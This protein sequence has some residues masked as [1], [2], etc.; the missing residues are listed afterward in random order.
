M[1]AID[2]NV[3]VRFLVEDDAAQARRARSIVAQAV[4][5]STP[6]YLSD[7][8]VCETVW[9]LES[10]YGLDRPAIHDVLR[11]LVGARHLKFAS[12]DQITYATEAYASGKGDFADYLIREHSKKAEC[13]VVY[14][15][16]KALW[17]E[18]GFAKL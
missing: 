5:D 1:I 9:V 2:T 6:V 14:T 7:I 13:T 8:V 15:F 18:P 17:S 4:H 11:S 16:D 10:C 3:L 12:R